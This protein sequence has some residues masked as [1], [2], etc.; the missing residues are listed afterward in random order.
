ML[1]YV[2]VGH[3]VSQLVEA[4]LYKADGRGFDFGWPSGRSM[5]LGVD[6]AS[7]R[8]EYQEYFLGGKGGRCVVLTT[9][10]HLCADRLE[11][12]EP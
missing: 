5:T 12:W 10:P 8:N 11:T 2:G 3:A 4:L 7:I 6:S 9:L 1:L